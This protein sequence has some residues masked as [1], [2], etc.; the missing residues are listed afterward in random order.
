MDPQMTNNNARPLFMAFYRHHFLPEHRHPVNVALHVLGTLMGLAYVPLVLL[1]PPLW[2]FALLLFPVVHAAPGLLGHR[3]LERS[4]TVGDAR[5]RRKDFP[6]WWFIVGNHLM[7]L[8][9]L[10]GQLR[11][12]SVMPIDGRSQGH[13]S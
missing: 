4:V 5:W 3:W 9:L 11:R 2:W 1:A 6:G 12:D 13:S 7:T 8:A 10:T